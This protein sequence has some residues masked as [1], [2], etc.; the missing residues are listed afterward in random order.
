MTD[1][2]VE[3]PKRKSGRIYVTVEVPKEYVQAL[4]MALQD[5][6]ALMKDDAPVRVME[7]ATRIVEE[8]VLR[9]APSIVRPT[10]T[11]QPRGKRLW[12]GWKLPRLHPAAKVFEFGRSP[13]VAVPRRKRALYGRGWAHPVRGPVRVGRTP[14]RPWLGKKYPDDPRYAQGAAAIRIVD[15]LR[16]AVEEG[17]EAAAR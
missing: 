2:A 14:P 9:R 7:K 10:I 5:V 13:W 3:K 15:L 4:R 12:T 16:E 1:V 6:E 11:V 17:W 8:E